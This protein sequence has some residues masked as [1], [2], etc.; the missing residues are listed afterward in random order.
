MKSVPTVGRADLVALVDTIF[1][2][3]G[4]ELTPEQI[5]ENLITFCLNCP[6]PGAAMD[7]ALDAPRG[8]LASSVVDQALALP[9]RALETWSI[10][11]IPAD[12]PL[13]HWKLAANTRSGVS[14]RR[15]QDSTF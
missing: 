14:S 5:Y 12:H 9:P 1:Y 7:L 3:S 6:D 2:P 8:T 4:E 15:S 13:R 10:E 11:E